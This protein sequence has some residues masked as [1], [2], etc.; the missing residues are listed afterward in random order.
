MIVI[1]TDGA[2]SPSRDVGGV[3]FVVLED[4]K[5]I[6]V[7]FYSVPNTTNNR[8][9]IEAAIAA[10]EWSIEQQHS[11]I[12]IYTDSMYIIGT[13]TKN[14][15][16]NVNVDLWTILDS[17]VSKVTVNWKHV[18]GHSGN[19]YNELCDVLAVEASKVKHNE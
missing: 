1:Y 19:K 8:M 12:T 2:Y 4:E 6:H 5:K 16:R 3:A 18:K 10:C 7:G 11:E 9:E 13:M 14:W 17:L 15:K